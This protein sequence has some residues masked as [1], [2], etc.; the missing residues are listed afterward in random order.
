MEPT[1]GESSRSDGQPCPPLQKLQGSVIQNDASGE[2]VPVV[3]VTPET[4]AAIGQTLSA[5]TSKNPT[6]SGWKSLSAKVAGLVIIAACV[7]G[8]LS[9]EPNAGQS[10]H[11]HGGHENKRLVVRRPV[12]RK[13]SDG[14][15]PKPSPNLGLADVAAGQNQFSVNAGAG[16]NNRVDLCENRTDDGFCMMQ[17]RLCRWVDRDHEMLALIDRKI[18]AVQK[19]LRTATADTAHTTPPNENEAARV[20]ALMKS[21]DAGERVRK[22]PL[23][24]VFRLLALDGISQNAV[25]R[26]CHCSASLVSMRAKEIERR[27]GLPVTVLRTLASRVGELAAVEDSR[28]R[29][30]Y[31]RGLTDDTWEESEDG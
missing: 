31:R 11:A 25:A 12:V 22:A 26:K 16:C 21:L 8:E 24:R 27:M 28:A 9:P 2:M 4:L 13:K 29:Q 30:I 23:H 20:F 3:F 17:D 5:H 6:G 10:I 14:A 7:T 1:D 15:D 19:S 18:S